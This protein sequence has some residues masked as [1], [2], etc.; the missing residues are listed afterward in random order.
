MKYKNSA[1]AKKEFVEQV[2]FSYMKPDVR[3]Q[4]DTLNV[5]SFSIPESTVNAPLLSSIEKSLRDLA[6]N[7]AVGTRRYPNFFPENSYLIVNRENK[8][9]EIYTII[10]NREHENVSWILAESLRLSPKEDTLS[11]IRGYYSYYPNQFFI[12]NEK[13]LPFFKTKALKIKTKEE[14]KVFTDEYAVSRVSDKFWPA[15]DKINSMMKKEWPVD[16]GYLDLSRY[17]ME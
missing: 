13:T 15:Y 8:D 12:V 14:Y 9:P 3:G 2:L 17:Q 6:S 4:I 5:K 1:N 10:K 7:K 16:F 11:I